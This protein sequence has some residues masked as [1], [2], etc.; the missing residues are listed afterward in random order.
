M[1][2]QLTNAMKVQIEAAVATVYPREREQV[3]RA[4][5]RTLSSGAQLVGMN[6]VL[7]SITMSLEVLPSSARIITRNVGSTDDA[8]DVRVRR[9]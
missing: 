4:I 1:T 3:R 8:D 7:R 5:M 2:I 9:F 6:E